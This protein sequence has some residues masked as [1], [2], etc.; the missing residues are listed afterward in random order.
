MKSDQATPCL[1]QAD[2]KRDQQSELEL[3]IRRPQSGHALTMSQ[4]LQTSSLLGEGEEHA[5]QHSVV[6]AKENAMIWM[7]YVRLKM[8]NL[9]ELDCA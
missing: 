8:A 9:T 3:T 5:P 4:N 1:V 2:H 7:T 6:M